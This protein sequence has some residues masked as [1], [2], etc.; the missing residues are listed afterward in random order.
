MIQE[1]SEGS[2]GFFGSSAVVV[3]V[4]VS[5]NRHGVSKNTH[6][7]H[8]SVPTFVGFVGEGVSAS[9]ELIE[10]SKVVFIKVSHHHSDLIKVAAFG[11]LHNSSRSHKGLGSRALHWR[12]VLVRSRNDSTRTR[13]LGRAKIS[14]VI[15]TLTQSTINHS[16]EVVIG[17]AVLGRFLSKAW[18]TRFITKASTNLNQ[19]F[20]LNASVQLLVRLVIRVLR[21]V[22]IG[23]ARAGAGTQCPGNTKGAVHGS[24]TVRQGLG[25]FTE[26]S[27]FP[28]NLIAPNSSI[29]TNMVAGWSCTE[30]Y[31][32]RPLRSILQST[33]EDSLVVTV[34]LCESDLG[35][36][37]AITKRIKHDETV[38]GLIGR[39]DHTVWIGVVFSLALI[40]CFAERCQFGIAIRRIGI[41]TSKAIMTTFRIVGRIRTFIFATIPAIIIAGGGIVTSRIVFV[42]DTIAN[43]GG[44]KAIPSTCRN[45]GT[46]NINR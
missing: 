33:L 38:L 43:P 14:V 42:T 12:V 24:T 15:R 36:I 11:E 32:L 40:G 18:G 3:V 31:K 34:T 9:F 41:A 8:G 39:T 37:P 45:G 46:I 21:G 19:T 23:L 30:A 26:R 16:I 25:T 20:L 6:A 2:N 1:T 28:R 13:L 7:K 44:M 22:H 29:D 17:E 27:K 5:R 10:S 4:L 35:F